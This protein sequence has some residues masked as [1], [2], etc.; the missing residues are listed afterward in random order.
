MN[1]V[2]TQLADAEQREGKLQEEFE[3]YKQRAKLA[4]RRVED[5]DGGV[6]DS[7]GSGSGPQSVSASPV[8]PSPG[9]PPSLSSTLSSA[10]AAM[11]RA[12]AA[13]KRVV[14]LEQE[15]KIAQVRHI[16]RGN[17]CQTCVGVCVY[18]CVRGVGKEGGTELMV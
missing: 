14:E 12:V 18:V 10:A 9:A 17:S 15:L 5:G 11:D 7:S 6:V 16:A 8:V 4:L 3:R 13:E 2:K 1:A